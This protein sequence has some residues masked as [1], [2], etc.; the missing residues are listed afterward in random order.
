MTYIELINHFWQQFENKGMKPNDVLLY[1]YL[2]KECN[3]KS[4]QNP[5]PLP[6]KKVVIA[7][8]I[9]EK[10]IIDSRQRLVERKLIKF[11]GGVRNLS[12]PEYTII[13]VKDEDFNLPTESRT[14]D[15]RQKN[16]RRNVTYNK[17]LKTKDNISPNGDNPACAQGEIFSQKDFDQLEKKLPKKRKVRD[18]FKPPTLEEVKQHFLTQGADKRIEYWEECAG[19]FY[20]HFT[21]YGWKG[22]QNRHIE[23]WDSRANEWISDEE[24][25]QREK[26]QNEQNTT[27]RPGAPSGGVTIRG[28]VTPACGLERADKGGEAPVPGSG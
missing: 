5:F 28:R 16:G 24:Q 22:S 23:R 11:K 18:N 2:L 10:S 25:R 12:P 9:S 4:W 3:S 1:F 13:G 6:N 17:D 26:K 27:N 19:K 21:A 14:V 7:L 8:E 20:D 15:E